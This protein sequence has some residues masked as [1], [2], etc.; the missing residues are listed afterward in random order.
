VAKNPKIPPSVIFLVRS[1]ALQ[2][3]CSLDKVCYSPGM[4]EILFASFL[5]LRALL[6]ARP[7]LRFA[8]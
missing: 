2:N 7:L 3:V 5:T 1:L 8:R 4:A 6:G